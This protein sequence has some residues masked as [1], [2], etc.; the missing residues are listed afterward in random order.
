MRS[1]LLSAALL[2]SCSLALNNPP[3]PGTPGTPGA[4]TG[5]GG[6]VGDGQRAAQTSPP[7]DAA[8]RDVKPP[9][10][11]WWHVTGKT[12]SSVPLPGRPFRNEVAFLYEHDAGLYPRIYNGRRE[13]GGT[14]QEA[15]LAA[16]LTEL[17]RDI[18]RD[19]PDPNFS[20]W[21]VL[22]YESWDPVWELTKPE[23]R[24]ISKELVLRNDPT[25]PAPDVE[26]LA[27]YMY[28]SAA[29][30]FMT[31]T[32][33]EAK[34]VRPRAKWGYYALPWPTYAVHQQSTQWLW[35]VSDA[36]YPCLYT[37]KEGLPATAPMIGPNQRELSS[38]EADMRGRIA[39]SKRF[40]PGKPVIA[41]LWVRYDAVNTPLFGRFV[42]DGDLG[43]M[44]RVPK[45]AGADGA[46]FWNQAQSP[47]EAADLRKFLSE[48]LAPAMRAVDQ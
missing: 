24:E 21:A 35:D 5:P 20:G 4:Q 45:A 27:K 15:D 39:L 42:N 17:R 36:L 10:E 46:I 43:A 22:D 23:Y 31:D 30:R 14:P 28:E 12:A 16:H 8:P 34:R 3:D 9:F 32:I 2:A 37:Y 29:K 48:K 41:L 13:N 44:L 19:I 18:Q 47:D 26:R 38:Y 33:I 25:R 7:A 6:T 11:Y 40:A 1:A